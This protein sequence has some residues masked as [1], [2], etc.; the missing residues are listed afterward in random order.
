[1][2]V[3]NNVF[4]CDICLKLEST[5]AE[6]FLWEEVAA[7]PPKNAVGEWHHYGAGKLCCP[8]CKEPEH[9]ET[10]TG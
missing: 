2:I 6:V 9:D 1:M 5:V 3:Q 10:T 8:T 7:Q 4:V